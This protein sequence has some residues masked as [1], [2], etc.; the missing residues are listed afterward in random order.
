MRFLH[1]QTQSFHRRPER[2]SDKR[3]SSPAPARTLQLGHKRKV[4]ILSNVQQIKR[5]FY[6]LVAKTSP[7]CQEN[8]DLFDPD[9][10]AKWTQSSTVEFLGIPRD[11]QMHDYAI[12]VAK[13]ICGRCPIRQECLQFALDTKEFFMIYGGTTPQE[14]AQLKATS[15]PSTALQSNPPLS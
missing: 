3:A 7:E 11:S 13:Q 14:R 10:W 9:M 15:F 5:E 8:P 4:A 2:P 12:R 1:Q 6:S